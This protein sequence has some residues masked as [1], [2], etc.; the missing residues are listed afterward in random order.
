MFDQPALSDVTI[1]FGRHEIRCHKAVLAMGSEYFNTLFTN[2][3]F[4]E[5]QRAVIELKED[6]EDAVYGMLRHIYGFAYSISEIKGFDSPD[7]DFH[8]EVYAVADKYLVPTKGAQVIDAICEK[9]HTTSRGLVQLEEPS[10]AKIFAVIKI[11]AQKKDKD[12]VTR[13]R[14]LMRGFFSKLF[15][16]AEFRAWL[17][18]PSHQESLDYALKLV[19]YGH[20]RIHSERDICWKCLT[21]TLAPFPD[22]C[23]D[24]CLERRRRRRA[25]GSGEWVDGGSGGS[26]WGGSQGSW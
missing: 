20:P 14:D 12:A 11:L 4:M 22:K 6:D 10:A 3:R 2:K 21:E 24:E 17:E 13:F 7:P 25:H 8:L 5:S 1:K 16:L 19:D 15:K 26:R 9:F 23:S 18:N